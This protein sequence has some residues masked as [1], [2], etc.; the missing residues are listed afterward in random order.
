MADNKRDTID[1]DNDNTIDDDTIDDYDTIDDDD[2]IENESSDNDIDMDDYNERNAS[3]SQEISQNIN[4]ESMNQD[5]LDDFPND[6]NDDDKEEEDKIGIDM[7]DSDYF[8]IRIL[9]ALEE[10]KSLKKYIENDENPGHIGRTIELDLSENVTW[11]DV[12]QSVLTLSGSIEQ[13][14]ETVKI[15]LLHLGD[16][17][18]TADRGYKLNF[19][20]SYGIS[21]HIINKFDEIKKESQADL[22]LEDKKLPFSTDIRFLVSGSPS[23]ISAAISHIGKILIDHPSHTSNGVYEIKVPYHPALGSNIDNPKMANFYIKPALETD[24]EDTLPQDDPPHLTFSSSSSEDD[25]SP[26][27]PLSQTTNRVPRLLRP[28]RPPP[29]AS[30]SGLDLYQH[31]QIPEEVFVLN[32]KYFDKIQRIHIQV[33]IPFS[34]FSNKVPSVYEEE[35]FELIRNQRYKAIIEVES[36]ENGSRDIIALNGTPNQLRNTLNIIYNYIHNNIAETRAKEI[37][38]IIM[39]ENKTSNTN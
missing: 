34:F 26:P 36:G 3:S 30:F 35:I 32:G 33:K 10:A 11:L 18:C 31:D 1:D 25:G 4:L 5:K 16:T 20:L 7:E 29:S 23:E 21:R 24:I 37:S 22:T 2:T 28:L 14:S 39:W 8:Y 12:V 9:L 17:S 15:S 6:N 27:S 19:L 38:K 13:I